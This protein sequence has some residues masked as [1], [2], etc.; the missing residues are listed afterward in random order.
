M[1]RLLIILLLVGAQDTLRVKVSLVTVGVRVTDWLG[2]DVRG[3]KAE[4][5]S[6]FDDEVAQKIEF[7]SNEEQPITLGILLDRSFSMS[8]NAKLDRAKDAARALVGA[9]REG[10]QYFYIAFDDQVKLSADL[11]DDRHQVET[12]IDRT[13]LGGGTALY[14]AV[15]KGL[16]LSAQAARP[17][18]VLIIISDGADQHSTHVLREVVRAVRE[19]ELQVFTIGYFS[20]EEEAFVRRSADKLTLTDGT[21]VDNPQYVLKKLASESG[22]ESFFPRS[23]KEL[24]EAVEKITKDLRTQYTLGFYPSTDDD[25]HYHQLRVAVRGGRYKV[26]ARPGYSASSVNSSFSRSEL[27]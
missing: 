2:R 9:A 21:V 13:A 26:R 7:F 23:D 27:N 22:A 8:Y 24:S 4:N 12:A 25:N 5:F 20:P 15:L 10:S 6:V 11:T 1:N 17:R 14:D 18:Q 16:A 3:L 19:A